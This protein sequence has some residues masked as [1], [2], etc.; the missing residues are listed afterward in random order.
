MSLFKRISNPKPKPNALSPL[1]SG[2]V[3]QQKSGPRVVV[4][5]TRCSIRELDPD[6]LGGSVQSLVDCLRYARLITED[7][8]KA[9]DLQVSQAKVK[10]RKECGTFVTIEYP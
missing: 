4:R 1:E 8:C 9:I 6:N 7:S 5:I 2:A 10:T 3:A